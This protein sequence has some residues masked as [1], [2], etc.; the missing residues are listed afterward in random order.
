MFA[1]INIVY[2]EE[3]YC[4]KRHTK[5][6]HNNNAMLKFTGVNI[7]YVK[8]HHCEFWHSIYTEKNNSEKIHIPSGFPVIT[9]TGSVFRKRKFCWWDRDGWKKDT[10]YQSYQAENVLSEER[11]RCMVWDRTQ[12][13]GTGAV[14]QTEFC[15]IFRTV[16]RDSSG[17]VL[18]EWGKRTYTK[19]A[20]RETTGTWQ[21]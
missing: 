4:I 11:G 3:Q 8:G 2:I 5:D 9:D 12:C 7:W 20:F 19:E 16:Y 14:S 18:S 13:P 21:V 1:R 15:H 6:W 10:Q 17:S